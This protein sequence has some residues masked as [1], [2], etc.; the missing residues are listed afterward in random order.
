MPF[1][2]EITL[3][4]DHEKLYSPGQTLSLTPHKAPNP[5]GWK[6]YRMPPDL[7]DEATAQGAEDRELTRLAMV[8]QEG[9]QPHRLDRQIQKDE[10]KKMKVEILELFGIDRFGEYTPGTQKLKCKVLQV[11]SN[12]NDD[13]QL[14]AVDDIIFIKV[15]DPMFFPRNVS[16]I[17]MEWK[18]TARADMALSNEVG[19]YGFLYKHGLTGSPHVAPQWL[20]CWTAEAQTT[21][22]EYEGRT[23]HV[24]V[25]ALEYI[26]GICLQKLLRTNE[27]GEHH[28]IGDRLRIDDDVKALVQ[29]DQAT[30]FG[31]IE[32]LLA[33]VVIQYKVG[34]NHPCIYPENIVLSFRRGSEELKRPRV[35]LVGYKDSIVNPLRHPPRNS[36]A[37]YPKPIHPFFRI[38]Y[39]RLRLFFLC[40][41]FPSD[42]QPDENERCRPLDRWLMNTFGPFA[43]N[44]KYNDRIERNPVI[45]ARAAVLIAAR[46]LREKAAAI[47]PT[48]AEETG[49]AES[50]EDSQK[51]REPVIEPNPTASQ[52][53]ETSSPNVASYSMPVGEEKAIVSESTDAG[54]TEAAES[55]EEPQKA[56]DSGHEDPL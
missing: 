25:I 32:D 9:N 27:D 34:V 7:K 52:I 39:K 29:L 5:W 24:G 53:E 43:D 51:T 30:R 22:L 10:S 1:L 6:Y 47:K 26:D 31:V 16:A 14:P 33:D 42:W 54:A 49:M 44:E 15:F 21:D 28:Y 23:R 13:H 12:S 11:P 56:G 55:H 3:S 45:A 48:E 17:D 38:S 41:W 4:R 20:G 2:D 35:S 40:R 37:D 19:A 46:R 50:H 8:F 36:F 18:V